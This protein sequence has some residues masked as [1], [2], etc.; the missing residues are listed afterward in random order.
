M[1]LNQIKPEFSP[2]V[3]RLS[4]T[5]PEYIEVNYI[6]STDSFTSRGTNS[7][8][9]QD[10]LILSN[11]IEKNPGPVTKQRPKLLQTLFIMLLF[12]MITFTK[13]SDTDNNTTYR[14]RSL[15]QSALSGTMNLLILKFKNRDQHLPAVKTTSAYCVILLLIWRHSQKPWPTS[16]NNTYCS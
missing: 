7:N 3:H 11:D 10:K 13:T 14:D 8:Y 2:F 12:V 6:H 1:N 9:Q 15:H 16:K 4:T 5:G